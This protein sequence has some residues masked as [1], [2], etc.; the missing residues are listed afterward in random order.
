[1]MAAGRVLAWARWLWSGR[2]R[3]DAPNDDAL[4]RAGERE[5]ARYL[6]RSGY[7]VL[8]R[9]VRVRVGEADLV[10]LAPDGRTAVIMEVKC[11]EVTRGA[12]GGARGLPPEASVTAEK[13]KKLASV[14]RALVRANGWEDRAVRID[15]VGVEREAMGGGRVKWTV[16]H[17][18]DAV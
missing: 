14:R 18:E 6:R 10:C 9:N 17:F 5:A 16:R 8:D 3:S 1:M 2:M 15:V 7:R 11:R 4:G 12:D 13:R